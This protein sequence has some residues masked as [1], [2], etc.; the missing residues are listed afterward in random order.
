MHIYIG[1][2][3]AGILIVAGMFFL[4]SKQTTLPAQQPEALGEVSVLFAGDM[5]FDRTIRTT[6]EAHGGDYLFQCLD[7]VFKT[8]DLVV[9]N[10]EGP[11]TES[12]SISQFS[13]PG[14]GNNFTF[15]FP[16]TTAGLLYAHNVRMV[17]LGNNH[18]F[19]YHL[20][21]VLS[22]EKFLDEAQVGHFGDPDKTEP[23][24]VA[25][26][27]ING[28]PF[29]FVNWSDWTSDNTDITAA[30][31]KKEHEEGR[32]VVIFT[33]WG[34]EYLPATT[35]EK[36]LAHDF[37]DAGADIIIG[38]HPHIVQEH[39][40]Y[41]GKNIYYSLGNLIFDQYF[42]DQVDHGLMVQARFDKKGIQSI[43]EIPVYLQKNRQTCPDPDIHRV[44]VAEAIKG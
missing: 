7:P 10:L 1:F 3:T 19:N 22:T 32:L 38:T 44:N 30:Q 18:I 43:T 23:N 9:A 28:I 25:R 2:I 36:R 27:E 29:S 21:G 24:K 12:T 14:D 37:I 26:I 35:R 41:K 17:N 39:E 6:T 15:T 33:H 13:E 20:A 40:L 34:E 16:T 8:E 11:I 31:I 42:S 5:M 4:N